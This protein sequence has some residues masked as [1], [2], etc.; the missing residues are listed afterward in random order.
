MTRNYNTS[1]IKQNYSY[2][3]CEI[4]KLF[5]VHVRTVRSWIKDGLDVVEGV[6][7]YLVNGRILKDFLSNK[8]KKRKHKLSDNEIFCVKCRGGV[9]PLNNS[10]TLIY[11]GKTVG[12][13][14]KDF[15]IQGV[16]PIC[17]TKINR[18]SNENKLNIVR[19]TFTIKE[20]K[21]TENAISKNI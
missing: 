2:L 7:P 16:C 8:Q 18:F 9:A 21:E 20:V 11:S 10:V 4:S 12:K 15:I 19:A 17:S 5:G 3:L 13:G 14:I 1:G 6:F